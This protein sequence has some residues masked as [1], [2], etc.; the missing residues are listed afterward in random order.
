MRITIDTLENESAVL[1]IEDHYCGN[2]SR[3]VELVNLR[4]L[5]PTL[6]SHLSNH[7][8]LIEPFNHASLSSEENTA[9]ER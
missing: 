4:D 9:N 7:S 2:L 5:V 6:V 1:T 8:N 3:E